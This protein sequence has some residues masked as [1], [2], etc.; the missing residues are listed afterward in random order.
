[1]RGQ[2]E[3][4]PARSGKFAPAVAVRD[5][6]AASHHRPRRALPFRD[7]R[8]AV[9]VR[10]DIPQQKLTPYMLIAWRARLSR[11]LGAARLAAR[12][13]VMLRDDR[14]ANLDPATVLL[15]LCPAGFRDPGFR[16]GT[17]LSP[18]TARRARWLHPGGAGADRALVAV[19]NEVVRRQ[20]RPDKAARVRT[21]RHDRNKRRLAV[22]LALPPAR[23]FS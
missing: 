14:H 23:G 5:A 19:A 2:R 10:T 16:R 7:G 3:C 22:G 21:R 20:P 9:V 13:L 1:M 18:K 12:A 6:G 11:S 4:M 15:D 8:P 17:T